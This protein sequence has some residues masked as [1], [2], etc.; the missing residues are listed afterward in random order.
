[1]AQALVIP[2]G[3]VASL[4]IWVLRQGAGKIDQCGEASKGKAFP[5]GSS[6]LRL[7]FR[8]ASGYALAFL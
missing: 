1:M 8:V 4:C 2:G 7:A 6:P 5:L 3:R